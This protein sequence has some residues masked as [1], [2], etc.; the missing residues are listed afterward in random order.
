MPGA[1][2]LSAPVDAQETK[3][4]I[5]ERE[6]TARG[7]AILEAA[8][9]AT[10]T[11][12]L[13]FDGWRALRT[14]PVSRREWGKGFGEPGMA[15]YLYIRYAPWPSEHHITNAPQG[16]EW[17]PTTPCQALVIWIEWKRLRGKRSTKAA[18]HQKEWHARERARG[19]LTLIAGEDFPAI[20]EGFKE[21]YMKSGLNRKWAPGKQNALE[22]PA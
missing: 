3:R 16:E 1:L 22:I 6:M 19:A 7:P 21:W 4:G 12:F 17:R 10:C 11:Q 15:D 9:Q 5:E 2:H 20:F 18:R 8:L 14:D 13:E